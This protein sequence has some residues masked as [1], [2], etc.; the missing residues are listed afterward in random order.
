MPLFKCNNAD[1]LQTID[2]LDES[3][4]RDITDEYMGEGLSSESLKELVESMLVEQVS[5]M[6]DDERNQ[7]LN[8]DELRE[9]EE[10][11]AVGRRSIVRMN[12]FDDLQRRTHLASLQMAKQKG[13]A[14][15]EL[16]RKNRV[17]ERQLLQRIYKKYANQVRRD[18]IKAQRQLV[19]ISPR[20]FDV[21]RITR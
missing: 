3:Y 8:S 13:D 6:S 21:T 17:K 15:W 7:Y 14:D 1:D 19:K 12:K 9:L 11:G 18:A 4:N 16:L 2:S 20:A 5:M 10:A